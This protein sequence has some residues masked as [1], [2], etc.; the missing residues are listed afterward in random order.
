MKFELWQRVTPG[1]H[2]LVLSSDTIMPLRPD[3]AADE[4]L[5]VRVYNSTPTPLYLNT[6]DEFDDFTDDFYERKYDMNRY[7]A[8]AEEIRHPDPT[9]DL[10]KFV[11]DKTKHVISELNASFVYD[12][13]KEELPEVHHTLVKQTQEVDAVNPKHYQNIAAGKQYIELMVDMLEGKTGIEAHLFGQTYK[14]LMRCGSKDEELQELKKALWYLTAL[15][16]YK[17]TGEVM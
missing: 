15:V 17:E 5:Y 10:A 1:H 2:K 14:Y 12:T 4:T 3:I 11:K 7:N 9:T 8:D 13:Q 6:I 16:K